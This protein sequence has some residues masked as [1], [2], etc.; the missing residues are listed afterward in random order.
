M[1]QTSTLLKNLRQLFIKEDG[2]MAAF[3][4]LL[5]FMVAATSLA[6][7]TAQV[8]SQENMLRT[9]LE[10]VGLF[11][12]QSGCT[13]TA[14]CTSY[15]T[16]YLQA[17]G[18]TITPTATVGT[19]EVP[20]TGSGV[21]HNSSTFSCPSTSSCQAAIQVTGTKTIQSLLSHVSGSSV[22]VNAVSVT[23]LG[24]VYKVNASTSAGDGL[25][26]IVLNQY[27]LTKDNLASG[28]GYNQGNDTYW[29]STTSSPANSNDIAIGYNIDDN[30]GQA[31]SYNNFTG[32]GQRNGQY[33]QNTATITNWKSGNPNW[34]SDTT[35][36]SGYPSG[37]NLPSNNP[38]AITIGDTI[39][40][41]NSSNYNTVS[42]NYRNNYRGVQSINSLP[43]VYKDSNS[44]WHYA[45]PVNSHLYDWA[46][47]GK[48]CTVPV[49]NWG[50]Y[51]NP[52]ST[53]TVVAFVNV[54]IDHVCAG[55]AVWLNN[56]N[57]WTPYTDDTFTV[58]DSGS[59]KC[60][61]GSNSSTIPTYLVLK[62]GA[63]DSSGNYNPMYINNQSVRGTPSGYQARDFGVRKTNG[64]VRSI[65]G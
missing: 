31:Y 23:S 41:N 3:V 58:Q 25:C 53:G 32:Y 20:S 39:Y 34:T 51:S 46:T 44:V 56:G 47:V 2:N 27:M 13:T 35:Q 38:T 4:L 40:L 61:Y 26:P 48:V 14:S 63:Y 33:V 62:I 49:V 12:N 1:T 19:W 16:S 59:L 28:G 55:N 11:V 50:S 54:T 24:N 15:A 30:N 57:S 10:S 7:N 21:F 37:W 36:L 60:N 52:S 65:K 9:Q 45:P 42:S 8:N 6:V 64:I 22:N 17:I 5:P 29:K 43:K 18:S